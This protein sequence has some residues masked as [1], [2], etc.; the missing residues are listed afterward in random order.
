MAA[1]RGEDQATKDAWNTFVHNLGSAMSGFN[2][3]VAEFIKSM[4]ANSG[5]PPSTPFMPPS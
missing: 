5:T 3:Y 1:Y 2:Y 4:I